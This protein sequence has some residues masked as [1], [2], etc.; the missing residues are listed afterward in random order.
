MVLT[1]EPS[2][3][4]PHESRSTRTEAQGLENF[5]H[6]L[7]KSEHYEPNTCFPNRVIAPLQVII[8][9]CFKKAK[10]QEV[11]PH[12]GR[13][14]AGSTMRKYAVLEA[15]SQKTL[16]QPARDAWG[17][18]P[19]HT[20]P[21]EQ[22]C[23]R[24]CSKVSTILSLRGMMHFTGC[25]RKTKWPHFYRAKVQMTIVIVSLHYFVLSQPSVLAN[26]NLNYG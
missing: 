22:P 20:L 13:A 12:S 7:H 3:V 6:I 8:L 17:L 18:M 26:E 16:G 19:A 2:T 14:H 15:A 25:G 4:K 9:R 11:N 5:I 21:R 10:L 1:T 24:T 23:G